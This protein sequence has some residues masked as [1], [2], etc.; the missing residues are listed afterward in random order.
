MLFRDRVYSLVVG[1]GGDT[2]EINNLQVKFNVTKTSNN[3]ENKNS[4]IVEIYNLSRD[5]RKALEET[6]VQVRLKAGYA[7]PGAKELF[8]GQVINL[9]SSNLPVLL[10]TKSGTDVV[11]KLQI[12]ELYEELNGRAISKLIPEG[13]TVRDAINEIAK[14]V[15]EITRVEAKGRNINKEFPD[16][17]QLSGSPKKCLE[18]LA[19]E[20]DL[21]WQV[22]QTTLYVTDSGGS[23]ID[24]GEG[25]ILVSEQSGL[26]G[27]IEYINEE[28]DKIRRNV[29]LKTPKYSKDKPNSIRFRMLL[30]GAIVAGTIVKIEHGDIVGHFRV[31]EVRHVG[32]FR[33]ND[34]YSE[35]RCSEMIA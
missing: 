22:D 18:S 6:Y 17:Y 33:G 25:Y 2:V 13:Q 31:D 21:D 15:P 32:D 19:S 35:V 7:S 29:N 20:Y 30:D 26:I 16:G 24:V 28:S 23:F 1:K 10:S 14:E 4:A 8:T 12:D 27:S 11:T 34:W 9:Y 3:S 5:R